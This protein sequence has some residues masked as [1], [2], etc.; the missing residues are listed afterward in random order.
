LLS[1]LVLCAGTA[2]AQSEAAP[3]AE[4]SVD[5]TAVAAAQAACV[6]EIGLFCK[7]ESGAALLDCLSAY[8]GTATGR[9]RAA[10]KEPDPRA[11]SA[12]VWAS[13]AAA[14]SVSGSAPKSFGLGPGPGPGGPGFDFAVVEQTNSYPSAD[15][16]LKELIAQLGTTGLKDDGDGA[17]ADARTSASL[18]FSYSSAFRGGACALASAHVRLT[19]AQSL[20]KRVDPAPGL[21]AAWRKAESVLRAHEEGHK[22]AAARVGKEFLRR[23][24]ALGSRTSCSDLDADV[25]SLYRREESDVRDRSAAYDAQT[26]HGRKQWE[27]IAKSGGRDK[28]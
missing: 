28:P 12:K 9:C 8:R 21:D 13:P 17:A 16:R 15:A 10:L 5:E 3:D 18:G 2:S 20:P 24:Q 27:Q 1:A 26:G 23:L 4:P 14:R 25:L 22:Q 11:P 6:N 19:V 7:G